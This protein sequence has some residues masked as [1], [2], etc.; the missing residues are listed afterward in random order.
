MAELGHF[1]KAYH[2]GAVQLAEEVVADN[3]ARRIV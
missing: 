1:T 2:F 3:E